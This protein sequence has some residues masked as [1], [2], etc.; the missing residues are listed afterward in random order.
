MGTGEKRDSWILEGPRAHL[1][2]SGD[3]GRWGKSE[4][5]WASP[6]VSKTKM[7]IRGGGQSFFYHRNG[8]SSKDRFFRDKG[9]RILIGS[10]GRES[11]RRGTQLTVGNPISGGG[12]STSENSGILRKPRIKEVKGVK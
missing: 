9:E 8:L 2:T 6:A 4:G 1:R 7:T 5:G 10:L 3:S 12:G 11:L